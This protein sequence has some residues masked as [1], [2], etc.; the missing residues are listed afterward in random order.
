MK[1]KHFKTWKKVVESLLKNSKETNKNLPSGNRWHQFPSLILSKAKSMPYRQRNIFERLFH[2]ALKRKQC[3]EYQN[4]KYE[5]RTENS[6]ECLC[7][8]KDK[9][10]S[11]NLILCWFVKNIEIKS[12]LLIDSVSSDYRNTLSKGEEECMQ[13][14]KCQVIVNYFLILFYCNRLLKNYF[15]LF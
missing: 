12:H 1:T 4:A 8:R 7:W 10:L 13:S 15:I 5:I 3:A 2:F 14:V 9:L 6:I 11:I